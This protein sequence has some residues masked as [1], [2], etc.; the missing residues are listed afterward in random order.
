MALPP[1]SMTTAARVYRIVVPSSRLIKSS[2]K[3]LFPV[4]LV[5]ISLISPAGVYR[6]SQWGNFIDPTETQ[7][8]LNGE[9]GKA[10]RARFLCTFPL[11]IS[12]CPAFP[13]LAKD[14]MPS[15]YTSRQEAQ[16]EIKI[17][18]FFTLNLW[19]TKRPQYSLGEV[20]PSEW[21]PRTS[22]SNAAPLAPCLS[23]YLSILVVFFHVG[24]QW[25]KWLYWISLMGSQMK[26]VWAL[27]N[28]L[29]CSEAYDWCD[30]P[31][32]SSSDLH[33]VQQTRRGGGGETKPSTQG[34]Q[35]RGQVKKKKSKKRVG[36]SHATCCVGAFHFSR[37][38]FYT[39]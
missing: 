37:W 13:V 31:C 27:G 32:C 8:Q 10:P 6:L 23:S 7:S 39:C 24:G 3:S 4:S 9:L 25:F 35:G 21:C 12:N 26:P 2:L 16:T 30:A 28:K 11:L 14:L 22:R 18:L 1:S 5:L 15:L 34:W 17:I 29:V 38:E 36:V 19:A 20:N 33:C